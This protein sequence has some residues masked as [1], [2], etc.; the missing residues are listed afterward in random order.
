MAESICIPE[1]VAGSSW[2]VSAGPLADSNRRPLPPEGRIIPLD[3]TASA[4]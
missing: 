2:V 1:R 4:C 3:Q